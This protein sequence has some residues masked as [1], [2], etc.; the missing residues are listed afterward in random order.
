MYRLVLLVVLGVRVLG[1]GRVRLVRRHES[2][3]HHVLAVGVH[4]VPLVVGLA[5]L[6][7]VPGVLQW[8][9]HHL[10]GGDRLEG[11]H[12]VLVHGRRGHVRLHGGVHGV[13]VLV[14]L[15][16]GAV[17]HL[18]VRRGRG[19]GL[20]HLQRL[21]LRRLIAAGQVHVR[22][23]LQVPA[24]DGLPEL[25]IWMIL[26]WNPSVDIITLYMFRFQEWRFS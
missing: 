6:P 16:V 18:A 9:V 15:A 21:R 2:A 12:G 5:P 7:L 17:Q 24:I 4:H 3:G 20:H 11:R 8:G 25:Y 23:Q 19:H 10:V 26:R 22:S 1:V 13:R 14:R